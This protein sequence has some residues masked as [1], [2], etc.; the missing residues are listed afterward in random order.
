MPSVNSNRTHSIHIVNVFLVL[1]ASLA[2]L[3]WVST[4]NQPLV[5]RHDFRQA[6]TALT[7]YFLNIS[8]YGILNYETPVL[9]YP[10][11]VPFEFPL[12]QLITHLVAKLTNLDL[13]LTGRLVSVFFSLLLL[14]PCR[15]ILRSFNAP[16]TSYKYFLVLFFSSNIYLYWSR[17]F[18]IESTAL[19]LSLCT[20]A[21]YF[22]IRNFSAKN[23]S[24]LNVKLISLNGYL[25]KIAPQHIALFCLLTI[26]LLAKATTSLA[27]IPLM[28]IDQI[29]LFITAKSAVNYRFK[30]PYSAALV[31]LIFVS[32]VS[33]SS[34]SV[35]QAWVHHTDTL[36]SLNPLSIVHTSAN[37]SDWNFG[38]FQQRFSIAIWLKTF[39]FLMV[40]P[41]ASI[42]LVYLL[43]ISG[44]RLNSLLSMPFRAVLFDYKYFLVICVYLCLSPLILF[45]NLHIVH[46]YYQYANAIYFLFFVAILFAYCLEETSLSRR[47]KNRLNLSLV[48]F[49]L[50]NYIVFAYIYLVPSYAYFADNSDKLNVGY[51]VRQNIGPE[52]VLLYQGDAWSSAIPFHALRRSIAIDSLLDYSDAKNVDLNF[53]LQR[54]KIGAV[55]YKDLESVPDFIFDRCGSV[56][57]PRSFG[58][59]EV[60]LCH[61]DP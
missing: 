3:F 46:E 43:I 47:F 49:I 52:Q 36:K 26:A 38:T 9:G 31:S 50:S 14:L 35:L 22:N 2:I 48:V 27:L 8:S 40:T 11:M 39:L 28:V 45:S 5:D 17:T 20:L 29:F 56:A 15:S 6:Q 10:W 55:V 51:Y 54:N 13:V 30:Y 23:I 18:M 33:L 4:I 32:F 58:S 19:F 34:L 12:Y 41:L 60:A 44:L 57:E 42:T 25:M 53:L 24:G 7:A 1:T 61:T 16:P 59:F 21:C 37:L